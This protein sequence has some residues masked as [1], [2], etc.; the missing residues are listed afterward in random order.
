MPHEACTMG[1][2]KVAVEIVNKRGETHTTGIA[3][4]LSGISTCGHRAKFS[5]EGNGG[6]VDGDLRIVREHS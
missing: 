5:K 2:S 3:M 1:M 4:R 6:Q